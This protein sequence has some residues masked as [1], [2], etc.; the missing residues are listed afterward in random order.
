M[1]KRKSSDD[2]V[3][4]DFQIRAQGDRCLS[5][6]F[7]DDISSVTGRICLRAAAALRSA[8]LPGVIDITPSF[9]SVALQYT[10]QAKSKPD[11]ACAFDELSETV[12][13]VLK[14]GLPELDDHS[15]VVDIPVCYGG[16]Y[17]PDLDEVCAR[18]GLTSEQVVKQHTGNLGMVFMLGFAP[19][20]P[21]IGVHDAVFAIP[22]RDTPRTAV[23]A[24]SVA[25]ANRQTTI[26]PNL[27]PGGWHIIGATPLQMF[28]V[29][30]TPPSRL[31]PGDQV[32][33]I[34]ITPEQ[35]EHLKQH[36]RPIA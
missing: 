31:M 17:G 20:L 19:G 23:P 16:Q 6:D 11:S 21:Y 34:S 7:G 3:R 35:Y 4:P 8:S 33:F 1:A 22:R 26:Y 25:I 10:P 9:N 27:L 12:R 13:A 30:Q 29:N 5:L 32:K 24:G 28:D 15:R 2:L 14:E 36:P 18:T